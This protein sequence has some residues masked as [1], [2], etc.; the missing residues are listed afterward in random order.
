LNLV[1][2]GEKSA[3]DASPM[4]LSLWA[5]SLQNSKIFLKDCLWEGD[6]L[7]PEAF[8]AHALV[9]A[10]PRRPLGEER[11]RAL[12]DFLARGGKLL[13]LQDPMVVGLSRGALAPLGLEMPWG[14][15]VAPGSALAGAEDFF[16]VSRD[17]PAHPI[18]MGLAQ[19]VV[20]PL[21]GAVAAIEPP[22]EAAGPLGVGAEQKEDGEHKGE[23]AAVGSEPRGDGAEKQE[24]QAAKVKG[25]GAPEGSGPLSHTW[26]LAA[27][28]EAAWLETD[29]ASLANRSHRYQ[30][31][32]D[33]R[34]PLTLASATSIS[35]GGRLVLAA[36]AD[37]AANAF[38]TYAGNL[39]LLDNMLFWLL[40]AQEELPPPPAVV[41]LDVTDA[42]ARALFWLP[43]VIWPLAVVAVWGRFYLRRRRL[44]S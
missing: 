4:G 22:R 13:A 9:L 28:S 37:L 2:D 24:G 14:L 26:A 19:P 34:G 7:P 11:E 29:G 39:A 16:V 32:S 18:T 17:Y 20:W 6:R 35:G 36:D 43:A 41:W 8:A 25:A 23:G 38:I 12:M 3:M 31:E 30:A 27:T 21:A 40:G 10:G 42:K 1:G 33:L 5:E 15:V 44:G